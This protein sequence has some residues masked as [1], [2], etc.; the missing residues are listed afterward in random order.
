MRRQGVGTNIARLALHHA[1]GELGVH[2]AHDL[3][4]PA[5]MVQQ[6]LP[7]RRQPHAACKTLQQRRARLRLHLGHAHSALLAHRRAREA[8]GRWFRRLQASIESRETNGEVVRLAY[9]NPH[10]DSSARERVRQLAA[11]IDPDHGDLS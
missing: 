1:F 5:R 6:R 9:S 4:Q 11:I 10:V 8:G 7:C 2:L 3:Q